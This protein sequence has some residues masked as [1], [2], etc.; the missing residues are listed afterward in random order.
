MDL[1]PYFTAYVRLQIC[2]LRANLVSFCAR[3]EKGAAKDVLL[4]RRI[5]AAVEPRM[6]A[7]MFY[8][9]R[10]RLVKYSVKSALIVI[11]IIIIY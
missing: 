8:E 2:E 9:L 10:R 1:S 6:Q 7:A 4:Q 3:K 11:I 5:N